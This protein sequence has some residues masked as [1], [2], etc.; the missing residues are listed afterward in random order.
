MSQPKLRDLEPSWV[1]QRRTFCITAL[2]TWKLEINNVSSMAGHAM[3]HTA[4]GVAHN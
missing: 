3:V 1:T 4:A 2:F